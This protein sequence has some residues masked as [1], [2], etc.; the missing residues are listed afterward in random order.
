MPFAAQGW[1]YSQS[2][3]FSTFNALEAQFQ[4]RFSHGLQTLVAFTWEKCLGDSN[5]DFNA[6]NG[7]EGAPYQYFFNAHI[8]KGLCTYDDTERVQLEHGLQAAFR[9]WRTL[10][11]PW[12]RYRES[13][14]TGRRTTRSSRVP[15]R[16]ST[17]AGAAPA[18]SALRR[19]RPGCVPATIAGVAPTSTD[20]ANLSDAAGSITGYSRPSVLPGCNP[21]VS[22]PTVSQWYNP[23]CFVSPASL[24]VG[25][26]Y[27]FGDTPLGFLRS[28]RWINVDVALVKNIPFGET[29]KLQFRAEAFN[30]VNHMVLGVPGHIDCAFILEW[31][32]QLRVS[33]RRHWHREYAARAATC[34]QVPL[35]AAR[36]RSLKTPVANIH[37]R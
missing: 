16:R 35:L 37:G 26:G 22:N 9:S 32:H 10:A 13:W 2:T 21:K 15:A 31:K 7:S 27:G 36:G 3:G 5:G 1:N 17:R 23:S 29:K 18:T 14:A 34:A 4:K 11:E 20:P 28:M 8:S 33:R 19:R 25:P 30:L 24:A 12:S 6:E